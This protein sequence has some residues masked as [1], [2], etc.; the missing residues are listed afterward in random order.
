M[1]L[2]TRFSSTCWSCTRSPSTRGRPPPM[3]TSSL[4]WRAAASERS[5]DA[6]S[7][8]TCSQ[9][10]RDHLDRLSPEQ[11]AHPVDDLA[12]API[13]LA[14]VV[15][16]RADL[17][18]VRRRMLHEQRRRLGIAQDGAERLVDLV[19]QRRRELAHAPKR[20]RRGRCPAAGAAS[21]ASARLAD[22]MSIDAPLRPHRPAPRVEL[23]ASV[24]QDPARPAVGK[25]QRGIHRGIRRPSRSRT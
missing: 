8:S 10:E 20:V 4:T 11:G 14:D 17:V 6:T 16:D 2:M 18:E 3:S 5:S 12:R 19:R 15:D 23:D 24:V 1:P 7:A 9:V 25:Q 22:V 21:P 13:V